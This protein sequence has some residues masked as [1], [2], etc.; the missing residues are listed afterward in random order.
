MDEVE[1]LDA[2]GI[3]A[4]VGMALYTGLVSVPEMERRSSIP[5][6]AIIFDFDGVIADS[7]SQHLRAFQQTFAER[8]WNLSEQDYYGS[9]S[10]YSDREVFEMVARERGEP[11]SADDLDRLIASKG[12]AASS[13]VS[14]GSELCPHAEDVVSVWRNTF[15][16]RSPRLPSLTKSSKCSRR[17]TCCRASRSLSA[18]KTLPS[19]PSPAPYLEAARR[20]GIPPVACVA[21]E[22]SWGLESAHGAGLRTIGITHTHPA[23]RLTQP[24]SSSSHWTRSPR[25]L[26]ATSRGKLGSLTPSPHITTLRYPMLLTAPAVCRV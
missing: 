7:E 4:V 3:D 22:D 16:L 15:R 13:L 26:S 14:A 1:Q 2:L 5:G 23:A 6:L 17:R 24:T 18:P 21:I 20:L 11:L 8:G 19:K 25:S 12:R 10:G 9:Y